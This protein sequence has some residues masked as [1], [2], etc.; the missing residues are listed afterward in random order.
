MEVDASSIEATAAETGRA[1]KFVTW[2]ASGRSG[3]A[4]SLIRKLRGEGAT[5][6]IVYGAGPCGFVIARHL[7]ELAVDYEVVA[8]SMS[9]RRRRGGE[10]RPSAADPFRC[11]SI[12][13]P[14]SALPRPVPCADLGATGFSPH[15]RSG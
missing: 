11:E 4:G 8:P 7:S 9:P 6:H 14:G 15:A 5:L 13:L 1:G 2:A 3:F 10:S 12:I